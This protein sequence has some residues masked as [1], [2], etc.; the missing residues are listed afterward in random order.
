MQRNPEFG[1]LTGRNGHFSA[2]HS[3]ALSVPDFHILV[4]NRVVGPQK[5]QISHKCSIENPKTQLYDGEPWW[6]D[7][8]PRMEAEQAEAEAH[9][10]S[11]TCDVDPADVSNA[12]PEPPS[13]EPSE[14]PRPAADGSNAT[15]LYPAPPLLESA[16][17][18][19][20]AAMLQSPE[21]ALGM[22]QNTVAG[23]Q[24][25]LQAAEGWRNAL[26]QVAK[27]L[28][29]DF[30][31]YTDLLKWAQQKEDVA[32]SDAHLQQQLAEAPT[33]LEGTTTQ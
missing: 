9:V 27:K 33:S 17:V 16:N 26:L 29:H 25:D 8:E 32:F 19:A 23:A 12:T 21:A 22:L 4:G 7:G 28:G 5:H 2:P 31:N 20:A 24:G 30:R 6:T 15:R 10:P 3:I 18:Q 14:M 1:K 11:H 13:Y